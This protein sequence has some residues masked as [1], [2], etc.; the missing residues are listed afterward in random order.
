MA[1]A[2]LMNTGNAV[3]VMQATLLAPTL[4]SH[5]DSRARPDPSLPH[6]GWALRRPQEP[7]KL[8]GP[9]PHSHSHSTSLWPCLSTGAMTTAEKNGGLSLR[10]HPRHSLEAYLPGFFPLPVA[11]VLEG[12]ASP[13]RKIPSGR[14]QRVWQSPENSSGLPRVKA[15][16]ESRVHS[17]P[18]LFRAWCLVRRRQLNG[19]LQC[20]VQN[21]IPSRQPTNHEHSRAGALV[22]YW[23]ASSLSTQCVAGGRPLRVSSLE[24]SRARNWGSAIKFTSQSLSLPWET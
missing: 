4:Q 14:L 12:R 19:N 16:S 11:K 23:R 8:S 18:L 3:S 15:L 6:W 17:G 10:D 7:L 13:A 5:W 24:D 20:Q 22:S 9:G 21:R 2:L 1:A